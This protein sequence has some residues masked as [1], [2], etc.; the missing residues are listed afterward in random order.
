MYL[1]ITNL[2]STQRLTLGLHDG[3]VSSS[4]LLTYSSCVIGDV[5]RVVLS[6]A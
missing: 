3:A 6:F 5:R 2:T 1:M 4:L